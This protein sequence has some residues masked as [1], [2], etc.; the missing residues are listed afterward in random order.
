VAEAAG[1]LLTNPIGPT[2]S[3]RLER[4]LESVVEWYAAHR[5]GE[6]MR[7][8]SLAQLAAFQADARALCREDARAFEDAA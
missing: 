2:V 8:I 4:A 6:D 7:A 1:T 3:P 5:A